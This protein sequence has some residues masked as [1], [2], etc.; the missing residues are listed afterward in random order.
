M[1]ISHSKKFLFVHNYKVAGTSLRRSL[2]RFDVKSWLKSPLQDKWLMI[3]GQAPKIFSYNFPT[4]DTALELKEKLPTEVF[5]SY[6]KF[7]FVRN[8][9]DWQVSLYYFMLKN[10]KHYQHELISSM[11]DFDEYIRW[12]VKNEVRLQKRFFFD[13]DGTCIVDYIGKI[14]NLEEELQKIG[15]TL[16]VKLRMHH[17]NKSRDD[18]KYKK[19]YTQET[20]DMVTKAFAEDIE[21][22]G[23]EVPTLD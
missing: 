19:M 8:P 18:N 20:L 22:F 23:Y 9:W 1:V 17:L 15:D 4:H 10:K 12:R 16:G 3:S 5:D 13:N 11:K 14:E 2:R 21:T 7:G 6:Y